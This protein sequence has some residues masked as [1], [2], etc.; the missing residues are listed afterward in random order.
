L[1]MRN[2]ASGSLCLRAILGIFGH[3]YCEMTKITSPL[4][5]KFAWDSHN[6]RLDL[7]EVVLKKQTNQPPG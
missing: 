7:R 1:L 2:L 6:K 3:F 5:I 4:K